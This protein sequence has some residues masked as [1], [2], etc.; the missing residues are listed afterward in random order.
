MFSFLRSYE[1]T[2]HKLLV[3]SIALLMGLFVASSILL[4]AKM[5]SK[6]LLSAVLG[7]LT[8]FLFILL[9]S[10]EN[11]EDLPI[12]NRFRISFKLSPKIGV[13]IIYLVCLLIVLFIPSSSGAQF[14]NWS[15]IPALNYVRL[16]AGVLLSSILPGY[17]LLVL[18]DV[19]RQ[20]KGLALIVFS[21]FISI[22]IMGL[23]S[24]LSFAL[25]WGL[26]NIYSLSVI[27]NLLIFVAFSLS[28]L[29]RTKSLGSE[30]PDLHSIRRTDYLIIICI[31][32]FFV[33]GWAFYYSNYQLGNTGDMWDHY[34]TVLHV[35]QGGLFSTSHLSYLNA[36][37]WFSMHFI[38]LIQL[39]GFPSLNGWMIYAFINF[40]FI[41]AFYL[42][43]K[44]IVGENHPRIPV[45]STV[46]ATLFAGFGWLLV[47]FLSPTTDDWGLI[48]NFAGYSTY[49]DI[50]YSF[51]Y[52]PIPQY[53]N[54]AIFFGLLYIVFRKDKFSIATCFLTAI[55]VAEG[56]LIHSPEIIFFL[57]FY[58]SF[59]LFSKREAFG[60]LKWFNISF[61]VGL[62]VV[63][64]IGLV[65]PSHFYF[66]MN[67]LLP[68]LFVGISLTFLLFRF[69]PKNIHLN[70]PKYVP[71]ILVCILWVAYFLS[72]LFWNST[73]NLN[74]NGN[75]TFN[76]DVVGNLAAV[77][78][79]PWYMYPVSAGLSLFLGLLG[80]T[81]LLL[82]DRSK[83]TNANFLIALLVLLFVAGKIISL[84][85]ANFEIGVTYWEKRLYGSFMIIP[86]SIFGAFFVIELFNRL[87]LMQTIKK[88]RKPLLIVISGLLISMII[89]SG[90][91]SNVLALDR[92]SI[93]SQIDPLAS[94][95]PGELEAFDYLRENAPI[96][97]VILGLSTWVII[98]NA[99]V[100][101]ALVYSDSNRMAY[102]L[103]GLDHINSPYWFNDK[104]L[105][106]LD[107]TNPE[108]FLKVLYSLGVDYL[109]LNGTDILSPN[110]YPISQNGYL[111]GH[112][113][114]YLPI[115]FQNNETTVYS[116]PKLNPPSAESNL[117]LIV[118]S[119]MLNNSLLLDAG[120]LVNQTY[121]LPIDMLAQSG[122][123]Y[124]IKYIE[125]DSAFNSKHVILSS[126]K[127]WS[128]KQVNQ[129][130][131]WVNNGGSLIVLNSD[132]LGAFAKN[133]SITSLRNS[134]ILTKEITNNNSRVQLVGVNA[135][136]FYSR[137]KDVNV[138]ANYAN[139]TDQLSPFAF[140]KQEG[141]GEIL[142]LN[143]EPLF[144]ALNYA[145]ES[146]WYYFKE[147]GNIFNLVNL[148]ASVY[149]DT[150]SDT[151]WQYLGLDS[152]VVRNNIV[153]EGNVSLQ[154]SSTIF[155]H[156]KFNVDSLKFENAV[157]T[158]N[159]HS[160]NS[161]LL[162]QKATTISNILEKG[163]FNSVIVSGEVI[164]TS[165]NYGSYSLMSLGYPSNITLQ[166]PKDGISFYVNTTRYGKDLVT[167]ESGEIMLQNL[168]VTLTSNIIADSN[169]QDSH[170]PLILM[171]TPH[172]SVNG[173]TLFSEA[174][175]PSNIRYV[176]GDSV[177]ITGGQTIFNFDC[178]SNN[179][180][181]LTG[182]SYDGNFIASQKSYPIS[183]SEWEITK[184]WGFIQ[185]SP[186][187]VFIAII[188]VILILIIQPFYQIKIGKGSLS[189]NSKPKK[190][191]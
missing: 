186:L 69:R 119:Y 112:L 43:V 111:G 48:L 16:F 117:T 171:R 124:S 24:F 162:V 8:F 128:D 138:I 80:L 169:L 159:G 132:G 47:L 34:Y 150:P 145:N 22:F 85:N 73:L 173:T 156:D 143:L 75:P 118:P 95:S 165:S 13:A 105:Q 61:I 23:T 32:M 53:L 163:L 82:S 116:V 115:V 14:V 71:I 140:S 21:F 183:I 78:S 89:L 188:I 152:M 129:S 104:T 123:N 59:I 130:L 185:T 106:F 54:L 26:D 139:T 46:I 180:F 113:I 166:V 7:V 154:A 66:N 5:D 36:E 133:L 126:D 122:F 55:L 51:I 11:Q 90:V 179:I 63:L 2:N 83:L 100:H 167:L 107:T 33:V 38:A 64:I 103:T 98:D 77:G 65:F 39:S 72:F 35:S 15:L 6:F 137:D 88:I 189:I 27:V 158:I 40:F 25:G 4:I 144:T 42:M 101:K 110:E 148:E 97:S 160:V 151:R 30:M 175:V 109:V 177:N 164:L 3:Y 131:A 70:I 99:L 10:G 190:D 49:N 50:I 37:T 94:A 62:F 31:F 141:K 181:V 178:S 153:L 136:E 147:L 134:T 87:R 176:S 45:I 96:D 52:G 56:L 57:L 157:G 172:V 184:P 121:N 19:K 108:L 102:V 142:Y 170:V 168:V 28:Q 18:I 146:S 125:D 155:S 74:V 161:S 120:K 79:E 127:G 41:L 60:K 187:S 81:Y 84:V 44:A 76:L 91:G 182:L 135:S 20:F 149:K 191:S 68:F 29:R 114:K 92:V 174:N 93:A 58:Y 12:S 86:I 17:G 1:I 9:Q 67:I